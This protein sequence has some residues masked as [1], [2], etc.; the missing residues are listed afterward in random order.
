LLPDWVGVGAAAWF[1]LAFLILSLLRLS[2]PFD[3]EWVEGAMVDQVRRLLGGHS[4]YAPPSLENVP[5]PYTPLYLYLGALLSRLLGEGYPPLRLISIASTIGCFVL[6]YA[7]VARETG[8]KVAG[9]LAAGAF[10]A[11]VRMNAYWF[12]LARVDMLF[13]VLIFWASYIVRFHARPWPYL[14]AGGLIV[15]AVLAKQT[16]LGPAG[17]LILYA[18]LDRRPAAW[19]LLGA[20]A[21]GLAASLIMLNAV[22]G[23]WFWYYTVTIPA[24]H[25]LLDWRLRYFWSN[26]L[27]RS[28][29]FLLAL[30][31]LAIVRRLHGPAA[32]SG[33][34]YGLFVAALLVCSYLSRIKSGGANNTLIPLHL[35]MALL[36]GLAFGRPGAPHGDPG[37][38]RSAILPRFAVLLLLLH[39]AQ[40]AY[41]PR[42]FLPPEEALA[43]GMRALRT[44]QGIEGEVWAPRYGNL[45]SRLGKGFGAHASLLE[46]TLREPQTAEENRRRFLQTIQE[47][48]YA[49]IAIDTREI[50]NFMKSEMLA[51]YDPT[52]AKLRLI[53]WQN[54]SGWTFTEEQVYELKP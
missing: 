25:G 27:L 54:D 23:G 51:Q 20:T 10:A 7:F 6:L 41:D 40:G 42:L 31:L 2:Y 50:P 3:M 34:F 12:D 14:A 32:W 21:V 37:D 38:E 49:A 13:I 15:L 4:L 33:L 26:D 53:I 9:L 47:R 5:F 39:F 52:G 29:A 43:D 17:A 28:V 48:H 46:D 18:L 16:A 8:R 35:G 44:L 22:Y 30:A 36:A 45:A 24:H 1:V 19:Y 11:T